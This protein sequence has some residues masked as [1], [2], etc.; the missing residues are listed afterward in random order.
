LK[1]LEKFLGGVII[2]GALMFILTSLTSCGGSKYGCGN[3]AP[4]QSWNKMVRRIN[5]PR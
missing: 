5:S 2:G 3:G 1:T 4:R